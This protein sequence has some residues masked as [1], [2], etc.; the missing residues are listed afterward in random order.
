[1]SSLQYTPR[2]NNLK[3]SISI[4]ITGYIIHGPLTRSTILGRDNY[5]T[6][7]ISYIGSSY[8]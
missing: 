1:M 3:Y 4:L 7:V 2:Y 8:E 5:L 6:V